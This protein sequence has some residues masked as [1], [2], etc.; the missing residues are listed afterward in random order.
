MSVAAVY[1]ALAAIE[2]RLLSPVEPGS[3]D[4]SRGFDPELK[5]LTVYRYGQIE[6]FDVYRTEPL[7]GE[8]PT[9]PGGTT[10]GKRWA[11][12]KLGCYVLREEELKTD[13]DGKVVLS[14]IR[15]LTDIKIAEP[16]PS[17]FETSLPNGYTRGIPEDYRNALINRMNAVKAIGEQ[18]PR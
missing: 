10:T 11:A 8:D 18:K 12:P 5:M 3:M 4:H 13:K 14:N 1:E 17:Y 16:D 6:G 7:F 9:N 15:T 2:Q